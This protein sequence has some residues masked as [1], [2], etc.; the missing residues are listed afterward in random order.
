MPLIDHAKAA[1]GG[2]HLIGN[3]LDRISIS[4]IGD[5]FNIFHVY[6]GD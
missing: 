2:F 6:K 5:D 1:I 4:L 3:R